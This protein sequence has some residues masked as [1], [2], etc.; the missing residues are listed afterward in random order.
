[1]DGIVNT[2]FKNVTWSNRIW[3]RQEALRDIVQKVTGDL[4]LRGKNPTVAIPQLRKEFDVSV[5]EAKRLA[6]IEGARV[7]I[8]VQKAS[9]EQ[10]GFEEYEYIAEPRACA[11]C[12]PMDGKHFKVADMQSG[13]NASP[14]HP[15][16]RCST[17]AHYTEKKSVGTYEE[18]LRETFSVWEKI[19]S[20]S[21]S[22]NEIQRRLSR[23]KYYVG[24]LPKKI[25][26]MANA[27]KV[28]IDDSSLAA[29]LDRH[30]GQYKQ[31]EFELMRDTITNPE[32]VLDNSDRIEGSF[33]LYGAIPNKDR[34]K[35]EAVAIPNHGMMLIHFSKVGVRQEK[36]NR[37]TKKI[38]YEKREK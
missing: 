15:F 22:K 25:S 13:L 17:A 16:C 26:T 7:Q 24:T 29:S 8:A 10:M 28:F 31:E 3:D 19:V 30:A 11:I 5:Y 23:E 37:K 18:M 20:G 38:L 27:T 33:L 35:M 9:F 21:L 12:K 32:T 36:K 6:V 4:V 34:V 14:M 2:P 1:M